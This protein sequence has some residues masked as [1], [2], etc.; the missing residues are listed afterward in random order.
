VS[1]SASCSHGPKA[2]I[3]NGCPDCIKRAQA[4]NRQFKARGGST[5]PEGI[6]PG[7][8]L[9]RG[10]V[11][12]IRLALVEIRKAR[13]ELELQIQ[14][15]VRDRKEP[16]EV[17]TRLLKAVGEAEERLVPLIRYLTDETAHIYPPVVSIPF[18]RKLPSS[19][20]RRG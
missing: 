10:C 3:T 14:V 17:L 13:A 18:S 20:E 4:R 16:S 12:D 8:R 9:T 7:L 6:V 1:V 19:Q 2:P 15:V 11:D 5:G